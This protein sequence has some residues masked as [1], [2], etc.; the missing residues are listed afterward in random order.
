MGNKYGHLTF[1]ERERVFLLLSEKKKQREIARTLGRDKSTI[2]RELKRGRIKKGSRR[3]KYL[4]S[5][6]QKRALIRKRKSRKLAY[7]RKSSNLR[8]YIEEGIRVGWSP[9]QISGR[10]KHQQ[11]GLYLNHESIYRYVYSREGVQKR[12]GW[13]LRQPRLL[14]CHKY[15]RRPHKMPIADRVDISLRPQEAA[16]RKEFGHWEGDTMFFMGNK[17]R[18]ATHVERKRR[19]IVADR[20]EDKRAATRAEIINDMFGAFPEGAMKTFTFDNGPE[21]AEHKK[22]KKNTGAD[23]YFTKPYAAWQKGSIENA[24]GLIRWFLPRMTD[25]NKL[26]TW[27][28]DGVIDLINNRPKKCLNYRTPTEVFRLELENLP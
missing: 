2:S 1:E 21:F 16:T 13:V 5:E 6:A 19:Y 17:Q 23:V 8:Q 12:L 18:L 25:I 4:A 7:V 3:P 27:K 28:L 9:E 10:L 26:E 15:G 24:N 20:A 14:R 22:I 11:E